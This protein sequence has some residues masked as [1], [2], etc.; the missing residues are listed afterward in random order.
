ML[1]S[2][3]KLSR[4]KIVSYLKSQLRF[5]SKKLFVTILARNQILKGHFRSR[6]FSCQR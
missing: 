6:A 4:K 2:Y 1:S 3:D 5:S